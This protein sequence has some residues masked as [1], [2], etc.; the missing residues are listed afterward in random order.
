MLP[1]RYNDEGT[2]V[3]SRMLKTLFAVLLCIGGMF[4]V[5]APAQANA[6]SCRGS[7]CVGR[8]PA[9][10][11]CANDAVSIASQVVSDGTIHLRWS[12]SCM[13]GW[14]RYTSSWRV[15]WFNAPDEHAI[16]HV[17]T[18]ATPNYPGPSQGPGGVAHAWNGSSWWSNMVDA[19]YGFCGRAQ[20]IS[21]GGLE[22]D[23]SSPLCS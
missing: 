21:Q 5:A 4:I 13:A 15:E 16:S 19:R 22:L 1:A 14:V 8:N 3:L 9:Q 23:W 2:T 17:R 20:Q 7:E 18:Q 11:S 12:P 10:T 6:P